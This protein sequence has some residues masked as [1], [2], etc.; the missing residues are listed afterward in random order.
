MKK[1]IKAWHRP[2]CPP[3]S[4]NHIIDYFL[5]QNMAQQT[6]V[7]P[8][9]RSYI[10]CQLQSSPEVIH[11]SR[12]RGQRSGCCRCPSVPSCTNLWM[13]CRWLS[14]S[15]RELA[16][17]CNKNRQMGTATIK[18]VRVNLVFGQE[19]YVMQTWLPKSHQSNS[20]GMVWL[21]IVVHYHSLMNAAKMAPSLCQALGSRCLH[22]CFWK[23]LI[24]VWK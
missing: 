16:S 3:N 13:L 23:R 17:K 15:F 5:P 8:F 24:F 9:T 10:W 12:N 22:V 14:V 20:T 18:M 19:L 7:S 2:S 11:C 4:Y 6:K 1:I 21:K